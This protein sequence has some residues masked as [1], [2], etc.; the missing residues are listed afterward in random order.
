MNFL[1]VFLLFAS[2][3][4]ALKEQSFVTKDEF[5]VLQQT[6]KVKYRLIF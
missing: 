6:L 4:E 2:A 3:I 1:L 5:T